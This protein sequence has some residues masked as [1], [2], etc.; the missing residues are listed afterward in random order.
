MY[1][2]DALD[3]NRIRSP[4][5]RDVVGTL[6]SSRRGNRVFLEG[7][8]QLPARRRRLQPPGLP[9]AGGDVHIFQD[10]PELVHRRTRRALILLGV[11]HGVVRDE[12]DV[13]RELLGVEQ[14][15]E[16][17]GVPRRGCLLYTSPSPRDKRQSRMPS[18]A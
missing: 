12:V 18:S 16:R 11:V 5:R 13:R 8:S 9:D 4:R 1:T 7:V 2:H 15:G 10:V 3:Y 6:E 14:P 17:L